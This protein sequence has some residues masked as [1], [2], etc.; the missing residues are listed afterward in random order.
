MLRLAMGEAVAKL[1]DYQVGSRLR[2]LLGDV[3]NL[4][5]QVRDHLPLKEKLSAVAAFMASFIDPRTH[6]EI[7]R[8]SDPAPARAELIRWIKDLAR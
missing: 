5:L 7:F 1:P 4:L 8:W 3:D 6:Q 2:W